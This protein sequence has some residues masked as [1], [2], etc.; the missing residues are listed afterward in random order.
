MLAVCPWLSTTSNVISK[1]PNW[2]VIGVISKVPVAPDMSLKS[3]SMSANAS[4]LSPVT[5]QSMFTSSS[6]S[7]STKDAKSRVTAPESSSTLK[8]SRLDVI[9]GHAR[10]MSKDRDWLADIV[11]P[12]AVA[13]S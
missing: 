4:M 10:S 11:T 5:S 13:Q 8:S 9:S 1:V 6:C 2:S 7:S 12:V 3:D